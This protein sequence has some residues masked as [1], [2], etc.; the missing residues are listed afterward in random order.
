[1]PLPSKKV[2]IQFKKSSDAINTGVSNS[3]DYGVD[4]PTNQGLRINSTKRLKAHNDETIK[5]SE[6]LQNILEEAKRAR[7]ADIE[8][9]NSGKHLPGKEKRT[10]RVRLTQQFNKPLKKIETKQSP[11]GQG[12]KKPGIANNTPPHID[13]KRMKTKEG[14][15]DPKDKRNGLDNH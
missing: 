2:G 5:Q 7:R 14:E 4:S 15:N 11:H 13:S 1:M 3:F 8:A 6:N 9:Q 12:V 10:G